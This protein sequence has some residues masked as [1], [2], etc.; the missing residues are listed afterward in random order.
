MPFKIHSYDQKPVIWYLRNAV[1]SW[2]KR[3]HLTFRLQRKCVTNV[4]ITYSLAI[5]NSDI[6]NTWK[7]KIIGNG[8]HWSK[9]YKAMTWIL[10]Q[11]EQN[12]E[13]HRLLCIP[14]IGAASCINDTRKTQK[15]TENEEIHSRLCKRM[16]PVRFQVFR[17]KLCHTL[18][19]HQMALQLNANKN[20]S[21]KQII[22]FAFERKFFVIFNFEH[23]GFSIWLRAYICRAVWKA[24]TEY[25]NGMCHFSVRFNFHVL[26][27][28]SLALCHVAAWTENIATDTL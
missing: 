24:S 14:Y 4:M 20:T 23:M 17:W 25:P 18:A 28:F 27:L 26:L 11:C 8:I 22:C 9:R 6:E 13:F 16:S 12:I 15:Y 10:T 21:S 19:V 2:A 5:Y 3:H 1:S 7:M